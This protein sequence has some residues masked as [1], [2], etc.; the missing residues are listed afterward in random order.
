MF[1]L[2]LIETDSD[3]NERMNEV[4]SFFNRDNALQCANNQM[5]DSTPDGWIVSDFRIEE[6]TSSNNN[7]WGHANS[8]EEWLDLYGEDNR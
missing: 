8:K 2:F 4:A 6:S 1:T 3:G 7:A 5:F